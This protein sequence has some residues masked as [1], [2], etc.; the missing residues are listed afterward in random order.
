MG[1]GYEC[2][3]CL[4][5][6]LFAHLDNLEIASLQLANELRHGVVLLRFF[7]GNGLELDIAESGGSSLVMYRYSRLRSMT[8]FTDTEADEQQVNL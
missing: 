3:H 4:L 6:R 2:W 5:E 7:S 1:R 8:G